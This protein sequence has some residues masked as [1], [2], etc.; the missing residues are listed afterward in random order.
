MFEV[1]LT[2]VLVCVILIVCIPLMVYY[3]LNKVRNVGSLKHF[4]REVFFK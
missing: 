2:T 4:L 1:V 3:E